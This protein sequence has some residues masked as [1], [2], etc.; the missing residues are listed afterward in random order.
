MSE[1]SA[2]SAP[3]VPPADVKP[4]RKGKLGG[5]NPGERRGGRQKEA[6][7]KATL[8]REAAAAR[9][10]ELLRQVEEL[11]REITEANVK[12]ETGKAP[13]TGKEALINLVSVYMSLTGF[14]GPK[15]PLSR[16]PVT[17]KV[18]S[19]NANYDEQ[20]FRYY[21]AMAKEAAAAL[22]PFQHPR[23]SAVVVGAS[24]VTKVEVMGGMPD[25]FS[26]PLA[27]LIDLKPGDVVTAEDEPTEVIPL[28][29]K[30]VA[31]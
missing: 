20:A 11:R 13:L 7:N 26:T 17:G 4:S 25:D 12:A 3:D 19:S 10:L 14:Y 5:S 6:K 8:V 24:V 1:E 2:Q 31:G 28:E 27:P 30:A 23:Y 21:S 16:D 18:T 22:T 9:E 29:P 15:P